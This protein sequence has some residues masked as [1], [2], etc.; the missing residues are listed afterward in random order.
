MDLRCSHK[1]ELLHSLLVAM[2]T[3]LPWQQGYLLLVI[4]Q[5]TFVPNMN[6]NY[7]NFIELLHNSLSAMITVFHTSKVSQ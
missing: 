6:L 1:A 2:A 4:A 3:V 7:F 5:G